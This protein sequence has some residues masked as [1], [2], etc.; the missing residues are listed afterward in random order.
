MQKRQVK[1]RAPEEGEKPLDG[2]LKPDLRGSPW[3]NRLTEKLDPKEKSAI[4]PKQAGTMRIIALSD[5]IAD[6]M[7]AEPEKEPLMRGGMSI[8]RDVMHVTA[9]FR[10]AG[11]SL[12]MDQRDPN[13][14]NLA[15]RRQAFAG[16]AVFGEDLAKRTLTHAGA[17]LPKEKSD[18]VLLGIGSPVTDTPVERLI[19]EDAERLSRLGESG[20]GMTIDAGKRVDMDVN[21][22][23]LF[24]Y[25]AW[26]ASRGPFN[27]E[28]AKD[29]AQSGRNDMIE[30]AGL[31]LEGKTPEGKIGS[32]RIMR[33]Y[34][35]RLENNN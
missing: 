33:D 35:K 11:A 26:A 3:V 5:G 13:G 17:G 9:F 31:H 15:A 8:D 18:R 34:L 2:L 20:V 22:P 27:T 16:R 4:A 21:D 7:E 14:S 10:Q 12:A 29:M 1:V 24:A 19:I 32:R 30:A 6:A 23:R 28:A 25:R